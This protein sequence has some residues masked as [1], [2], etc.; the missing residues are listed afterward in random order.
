[1]WGF[2][3]DHCNPHRVGF[4]TV[5]WP[6]EYTYWVEP[7]WMEGY[8][9]LAAMCLRLGES[10]RALQPVPPAS[11]IVPAGPGHPSTWA[12]DRHYR[13]KVACWQLT[14]NGW[15]ATRRWLLNHADV[16]I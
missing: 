3:P 10:R 4:V 8:A 13:A 7:R 14:G 2:Y 16:E 6:F 12:P 11:L 1:M 9:R 15:S 5:T